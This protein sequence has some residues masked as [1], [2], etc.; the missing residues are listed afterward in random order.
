MNNKLKILK[1]RYKVNIF[2]SYPH[3]WVNYPDNN[4]SKYTITFKAMI[5]DLERIYKKMTE[6][7]ELITNKWLLENK[8]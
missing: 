7:K 2:I 1:D 4:D 3:I 6:T 8:E 5:Y